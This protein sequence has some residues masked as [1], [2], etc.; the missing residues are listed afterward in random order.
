MADEAIVG[1]ARAIFTV[2]RAEA[3][4]EQVEDELFR[5]ARTIEREI[6]LRD[7]LIDL[8]LPVEHRQQMIAELLGDRVQP[9]TL[10]I[11]NFVIS[12]GRARE[13][14][15]IIDALIEVSAA[16]RAKAVAEVRT[17]VPL[18]EAERQ[19]LRDSIQ[20]A[21][22]KSVELK[23]LVDP[24]VLGGI[25]VRVGDLIYDGTVRRRLQMAR[26]RFSNA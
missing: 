20:R 6:R 4:E 23:V 13:L 14:P 17:A 7:A 22:G 2:A 1:Y 24:S 9:L 19:K 15:Q 25:L 11:I 10:N 21:T 26:E 3:V 18:G 12:Q 8:S 5:F 16:E